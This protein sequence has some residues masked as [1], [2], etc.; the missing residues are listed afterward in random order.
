[1]RRLVIFP[2][3]PC[4]VLQL[5][6]FEVVP[7]S[8][9]CCRMLSSGS[10]LLAFRNLGIQVATNKTQGPDKVLEFMGIILDSVKMEARPPPD[11]VNRIQAALASFKCWKSTTLKEWQSLICTLNSAFNVVPLGTPFLQRMVQITRNVSQT[12][13][14]INASSV[15]S[16]IFLLGKIISHWNG[17][18]FYYQLTG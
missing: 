11:K 17:A 7:F 12:H 13:N 10:M 16:K 5:N 4:H 2:V 9:I 18:V 15:F 3:Y 6:L 1:M 8:S 14:H